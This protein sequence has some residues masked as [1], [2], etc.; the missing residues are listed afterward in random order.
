VL[1]TH[2][3]T[4]ISLGGDFEAIGKAFSLYGEAVIA[5]GLEVIGEVGKDPLALMA[6]R[7]ELA[8]H[9]SIGI[10]HLATEDL[11]D[12]LVAETDPEQRQ[13]GF[14]SRCDHIETN[15]GLV[16]IAGTGGENDSIG[17]VFQNFVD[18]NP[19]IAKNRTLFPQFPQIMDEIV[20]EAVVIIDQNQH[21]GG[22]KRL[23]RPHVK[24]PDH[25]AVKDKL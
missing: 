22:T 10:D 11:S 25:S 20:G 8:M 14:R 21:N 9:A 4:V 16:R 19:V 5:G 17:L 12:R 3:C 7:T 1:K 6:D 24:A 2:N 18:R 13:A 23:T 15:T